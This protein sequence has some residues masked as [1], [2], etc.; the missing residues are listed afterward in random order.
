MCVTS[1]MGD[2]YNDKW[3]DYFKPIPSL[4][5][6]VFPN[7]GSI[8]YAVNI[9]FATKQELYELRKE[10]LEMKEILKVAKL[11]DEK[12]NE[13]YCEME[14]KVAMLKKVAELF[15]VSLEEIFPKPTEQK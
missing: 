8:N 6:S 4:P 11:Y 7:S 2:H 3:K 13:P 10:V 9:Q 12:N 1:A 5:A 15:G 14:A